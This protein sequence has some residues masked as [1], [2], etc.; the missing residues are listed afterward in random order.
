MKLLNSQPISPFPSCE[1]MRFC[2]ASI[3]KHLSGWVL[4]QLI[5]WI[6]GPSESILAAVWTWQRHTIHNV[7]H[8]FSKYLSA[9]YL[10]LGFS[11]CSHGFT[12]SDISIGLNTLVSDGSPVTALAGQWLGSWWEALAA[13]AHWSRYPK[14]VKKPQSWMLEPCSN[15]SQTP[16]PS[17]M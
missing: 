6:W 15:S 16:S 12:T 9:I 1:S 13:V 10:I 5:P 14:G 8:S 3:T 11:C 17:K 2:T 4:L 7:K